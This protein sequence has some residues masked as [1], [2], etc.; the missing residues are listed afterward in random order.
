MSR[1]AEDA[2]D[3]EEPVDQG[4]GGRG[5]TGEARSSSTRMRTLDIRLNQAVMVHSGPDLVEAYAELRT[6]CVRAGHA[7]GQRYHDTDRW[8]AATAFAPGSP[9]GVCREGSDDRRCTTG[10]GRP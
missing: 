10:T 7:L 4:V 1:G 8:I 9:A 2:V 6:A 5:G 3:G